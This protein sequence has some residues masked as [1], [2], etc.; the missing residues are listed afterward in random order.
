MNVLKL[1]Q[2][3]FPKKIIHKKKNVIHP[4][5]FHFVITILPKKQIF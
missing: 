4:H 5:I 2:Q 3:T 1:L